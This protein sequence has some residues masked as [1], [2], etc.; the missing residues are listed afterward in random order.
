MS[1]PI[2][3]PPCPDSTCEKQF[4][5]KKCKCITTQGDSCQPTKSMCAYEDGGTFYGCS[6]GCCANQCEGQCSSV[7][8]PLTKTWKRV[9]SSRT[10]GLPVKISTDSTTD[11]LTI[12]TV[13][14][15]I[16]LVALVLIST[17]GLFFKE[18]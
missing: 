9:S 13:S 1:C 18:A 17:L 5:D 11:R 2:K 16:L 14:L 3:P 8:D 12:Y 10:I 15:G 7:Y 6:T 4:S